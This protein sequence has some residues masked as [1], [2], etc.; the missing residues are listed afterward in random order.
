M[1]LNKSA[2]L[3]FLMALLFL[4]LLLLLATIKGKAQRAYDAGSC[5]PEHQFAPSA[6]VEL[7]SDWGMIIQAGITGQQS[8]LSVHAGIR[9]REFT[10][11]ITAAKPVEEPKL[12]PRLELGFR[13]INGL[14]VNFGWA[15]DPDV[16]VT[17]YR[18]LGEK[19]A[20]YGRGL[21]DGG[22]MFAI[23]FKVLFISY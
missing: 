20:I 9:Y 11:M 21:Y 7:T 17:A 22:L 10:D 1:K 12:M 3:P 15:A 2:A 18:R 8:R 5:E 23:G 6:S 19:I 16:S 4:T 13:V 14:H